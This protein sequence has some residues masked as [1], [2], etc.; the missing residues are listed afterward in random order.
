MLST[1][2]PIGGSAQDVLGH[3]K[4]AAFISQAGTPSFYEV[5]VPLPAGQTLEHACCAALLKGTGPTH[6]A[7]VGS[8]PDVMLPCKLAPGYSQLRCA[9]CTQAL[10][11][12]VPMIGA[13]L[14]A[15]FLRH[16]SSCRF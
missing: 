8:L 2:G 16:I 4:T 10:Y 15:P 12:G 13:P 7:L 14:C 3:P 9:R 1:H 6:S 5:R 11:H